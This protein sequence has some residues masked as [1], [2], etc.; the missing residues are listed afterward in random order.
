M[1][2]PVRPKNYRSIA[3]AAIA[4]ATDTIV[5]MNRRRIS[6]YSTNGPVTQKGIRGCRN[7]EVRDGATPI[8]GFHDHPDEMWIAAAYRGLAEHCAREGWL[9]IEGAAS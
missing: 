2:I 5:L 8:L 4:L 3:L 9:T 6:D 1:L 7:F